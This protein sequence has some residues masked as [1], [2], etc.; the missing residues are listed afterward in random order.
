MHKLE[1]IAD[2]I[3]K[4]FDLRT[5]ARDQALT[6]ARQLTRACSLAI[7]A[8]HRDDLET[9]QA[10]LLEARALAETLRTALA[11]HPDLFHAG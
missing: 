1:T 4:S 9:M 8:V 10:Q 11:N 6:Q 3:R 2:H 7:R 5:A